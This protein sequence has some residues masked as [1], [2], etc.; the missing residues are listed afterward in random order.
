ML[1]STHELLNEIYSDFR[2]L[3]VYKR[4]KLSLGWCGSVD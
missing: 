4:M 2:D 3:T 1:E